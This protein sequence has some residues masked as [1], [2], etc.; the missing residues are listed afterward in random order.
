MHDGFWIAQRK[1]TR[2]F[3][4]GAH[5]GLG[6]GLSELWIEKSEENRE[7]WST[8]AISASTV[9][10]MSVCR[11]QAETQNT[12]LQRQNAGPE[13]EKRNTCQLFNRGIGLVTNY[14][15]TPQNNDT[16]Q[17]WVGRDGQGPFLCK[18]QLRRSAFYF[19]A[20]WRGGKLQRCVW[21][22]LWGTRKQRNRCF[23]LIV[24]NGS[25]WN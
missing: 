11:D 7:C 6:A 5:L 4:W 20:T 1:Y 15:D 14:L 25:G 2:G 12:A 19:W 18:P 21:C 9:T 8:A 10:S 3:T 13:R 23:D 16:C 22:H 17:T 24:G